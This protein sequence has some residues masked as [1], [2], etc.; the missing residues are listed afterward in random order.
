MFMLGLGSCPYQDGAVGELREGELSL[1]RRWAGTPPP[2]LPAHW[3]LRQ[4]PAAG[5]RLDHRRPHPVGHSAG[6]QSESNTA[7]AFRP[8]RLERYM[9]ASARRTSSSGSTVSAAAQ[10]TTPRLAVTTNT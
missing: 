6:S 10:K 2:W 3:P 7:K 8:M 4:L 5:L 9:A 1:F